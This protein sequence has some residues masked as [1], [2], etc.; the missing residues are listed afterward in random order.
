GHV[1]MQARAELLGVERLDRAL[2]W[3]HRP[4]QPTPGCEPLDTACGTSRLP[5]ADRARW[6]AGGPSAVLR[7]PRFNRLPRRQAVTSA[8]LSEAPARAASRSH[9]A[10]GAPRA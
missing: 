9:P 3:L 1:H 7:G 4:A 5:L 2:D 10:R 8:M 6:G